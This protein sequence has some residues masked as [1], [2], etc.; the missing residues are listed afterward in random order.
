MADGTDPF[1]PVGKVST[2]IVIDLAARARLTN[3]LKN[4]VDLETRKAAERAAKEAVNRQLWAQQGR[5]QITAGIRKIQVYESPEA[6]IEY[7]KGTL[8]IIGGS[9]E[10]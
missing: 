9:T 10:S 3:A 8:L 5:D 2:G 6:A 1:T 7:L 4:S